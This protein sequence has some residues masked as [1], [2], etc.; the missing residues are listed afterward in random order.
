MSSQL[1]NLE[2]NNNQIP[3]NVEAEQTILGSILENNEIFDEI[4]DEINEGH[5]YDLF[6]KK[7]IKLFQI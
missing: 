1:I 5:F 4:T 7:F 2:L 6:I 3:K